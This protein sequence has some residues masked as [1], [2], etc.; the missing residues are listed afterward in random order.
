MTMKTLKRIT[1]LLAIPAGLAGCDEIYTDMGYGDVGQARI[2][3]E[4]RADQMEVSGYGN[5]KCDGWD[6]KIDRSVYPEGEPDMGCSQA[7]NLALMVERKS[8]LIEGR[9]TAKSDATRSDLVTEE[10]REAKTK[11]LMKLEKIMQ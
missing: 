10:Y 3:T 2:W 8:D 4:W 1:L 6:Y 11:E 9:P 5:R 7:Y